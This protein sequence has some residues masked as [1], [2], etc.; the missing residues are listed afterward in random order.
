MLKVNKIS[1]PDFFK[2]FKRK[3]KLKNWKDFDYKIKH[4]LKEYM[5]ENEQKFDEVYFCPYCEREI[6]VE[7]SQIEHVKPKDKFPKLFH[8]YKNF[9]TGCLENQT[10]GSFKENKWDDNFIN[11]IEIDPEEYFEYS[12]STG[13][14][15]PKYETGIK[16][17]MAVKTID[18]L[19]LNQKKLCESRKNFI[20][21]SSFKDKKGKIVLDKEILKYIT[22]FP[23]LKEFL[24][25]NLKSA[26]EK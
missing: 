20:L 10:C 4:E 7:K 9:L 23:T 14:I 16:Y 18:I 3:S 1:E 5:L 6:T 12:I 11:L 22:K 19:N 21:R 13:E 15:I 17:E 25:K 26:T 2:E 8:E 24:L